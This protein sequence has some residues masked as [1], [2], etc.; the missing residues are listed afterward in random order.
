MAERTLRADAA[1]N[2][3]QVL[4][5]ASRLFAERGFD[6]SMAEIA[7][8]AGVGRTTVLRNF[9]TRMDLAAALFEQNLQHFR[10]VAANQT[11]EA[12][13][14]VELFDLKL[15][16]YVRNGGL[17]EAVQRERLSSDS[18]QTDR[19]EVAEILFR[20]AQ[21]AIQAGIMRADVRVETFV[22]MQQA[23]G[24]AMLSGGT[25][26]ERRERARILRSLLLEGLLVHASGARTC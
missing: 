15:E 12:G 6:V 7:A 9:S 1:R 24:G 8:A 20:A 19:R 21:S 5:A 11:G 14:F 17:A 10:T 4:D 25:T 18:F 2:R 22:V 13:D 26:P 23:M 3:S 16:L